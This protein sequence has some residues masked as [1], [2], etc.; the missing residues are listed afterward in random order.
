[1]E[2]N[3]IN[4]IT[5]VTNKPNLNEA[6]ADTGTTGHFMLPGAPMDDVQ[7]AKHPIEIEMPNGTTERSTHTCQ[8][9]IPSVPKEVK[10]A[11]VVP[12]LSH[13]SLV[14]IK[15][16]FKGGYEV[17]FKEK[18]CDVYYR[19]KLVLAGKGVGPKGL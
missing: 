18:T 15:K 10:E 12:G 9:Q 14:L 7:P 8:L 13:S 17:K 16:L 1:M 5:R 6:I 3:L 2:I 11:H 4:N 19:G